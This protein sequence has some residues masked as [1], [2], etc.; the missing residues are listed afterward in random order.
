M[1]Y[2][3]FDYWLIEKYIPDYICD[4][5]IKNHND[6]ST[7][8]LQDGVIVDD[9]RKSGV[10]WIKEPFYKNLVFDIIT[11]TNRDSG[12]NFQLE[13][14]ENLQ[15]TRYVAP[16]GHYDFHSDGNGHSRKN[17]DDSVRKLSMICLLS[18]SNQFEGGSFQITSGLTDTYDIK[19]EKGDIVIFPSYVLHR[20]S[21]V[22]KGIRHS[23]VA[24]V[25]GR[26]FV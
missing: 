9:Y 13:Y 17:V 5:I 14:L 7:S 22:T 1:S 6:F 19:L 3:E 20:V 25:R 12:L 23:I 24:W 18:D 15:L 16:D 10:C 4:E 21:P 11:R 8:T 26:A 2:T